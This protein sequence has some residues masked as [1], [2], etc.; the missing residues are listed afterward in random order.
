MTMVPY[1]Y[2]FFEMVEYRCSRMAFATIWS[3]SRSSL[4]STSIMFRAHVP[5]VL[6][7]FCPNCSLIFFF[8]ANTNKSYLFVSACVVICEFRWKFFF[9]FFFLKADSSPSHK[10]EEK[11]SNI[12]ENWLLI[13]IGTPFPFIGVV[14]LSRWLQV[15][16]KCYWLYFRRW[17]A[18]LQDQGI[19]EGT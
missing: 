19:R 15:W 2:I 8:G 4:I 6:G 18:G 10:K 14:R 3:W 5:F 13:I 1:V 11:R 7:I 17:P 12:S 9:F 16:W